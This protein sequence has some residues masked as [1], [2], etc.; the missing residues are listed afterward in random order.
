MADVVQAKPF[1]RTCGLSSRLLFEDYFFH[2]V[3]CGDVLHDFEIWFGSLGR[4][5]RK[6]LEQ[7]S[8]YRFVHPDVLG[9]IK[10]QAQVAEAIVF[11]QGISMISQKPP[12]K[13]IKSEEIYTKTNYGDTKSYLG[14]DHIIICGPYYRGTIISGISPGKYVRLTF[15]EVYDILMRVGFKIRSCGVEKVEM[16]II[17]IQISII[18]RGRFS[19]LSTSKVTGQQIIFSS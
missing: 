15:K 3:N 16:K 18:A 19:S 1:C 4:S 8:N 7:K 10:S 14:Y 5:I 11:G 9:G 12:E 17:S 13:I 6:K 2:H